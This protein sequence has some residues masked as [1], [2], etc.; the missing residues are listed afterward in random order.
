M[1]CLIVAFRISAYRYVVEYVL[2][3][4]LFLKIM[5]SYTGDNVLF[6]PEN[7]NAFIYLDVKSKIT[8]GG[9]KVI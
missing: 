1:T 9:P 2:F 3:L 4:A 5:S 8:K 6:P 7:L